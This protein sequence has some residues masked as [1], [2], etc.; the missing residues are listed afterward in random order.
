MTG[1]GGIF[2]ALARQASE[3]QNGGMRLTLLLAAA[4]MTLPLIV[5][6]HPPQNPDKEMVLTEQQNGKAISIGSATT[7]VVKLPAQLGT[8]YSWRVVETPSSVLSSADKPRIETTDAKGAGR[9]ERQV[10]TFTPVKAGTVL[11]KLHYVRSWD[12]ETKPEKIYSV[13]VTIE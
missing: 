2:R 1:G 8:G 9:Q 13:K 5:C 12:K 7:L 6:A 11:L 3:A 4:I 10:F